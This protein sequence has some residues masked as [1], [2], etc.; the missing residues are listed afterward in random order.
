DL[1]AVVPPDARERGA[2]SLRARLEVAADSKVGDTSA[3][4]A[5]GLLENALRKY[6]C[7][8]VESSGLVDTAIS[9]LELKRGTLDTEIHSL[10]HDLSEIQAP[11]DELSRLDDEER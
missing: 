9:R 1:S 7:P 8:E 2:S 3:S 4:D 6:T 10:E 5:I 11:L